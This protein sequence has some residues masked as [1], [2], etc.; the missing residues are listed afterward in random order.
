M[1]RVALC[2]SLF[3]FGVSATQSWTLQPMAKNRSMLNLYIKGDFNFKFEIGSGLCRLVFP[4][5]ESVSLGSRECARA[6]A[7]SV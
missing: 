7:L 2:L 4:A 5:D 6:I 1:T 3:H